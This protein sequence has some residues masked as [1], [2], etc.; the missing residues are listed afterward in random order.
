MS[1][2]VVDLGYLYWNQR[3]LQASA[4]ASAL[5]GAMQLPD[6]ASSVTVAKQFGT[7]SGAKNS[8]SRMSNV[9]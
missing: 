6:P 8:D 2:M 3:S 1:A 4:D 7:G 5:A 9:E